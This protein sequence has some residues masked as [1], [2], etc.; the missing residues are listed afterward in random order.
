[1]LISSAMKNCFFI[2]L[3]LVFTACQSKLPKE[4]TLSDPQLVPEGIAYSAKTHSFYISSIAQSKI[5][6]VDRF[7]GKQE[8]F[9]GKGAFGYQPGVGILVDD[10]NNRLYALGGYY[11]LKDSIAALY[12][13]DLTTQKLLKRY[14]MPQAGEHF[15]NDLIKDQAGNLYMTNTKDSS[16]YWL[17]QN[18][19]SLELFY[20]SKEITFPNGI[21][22]SDDNAKL[23]VASFPGGV[24]I[25]DLKE[26]KL[27]NKADS[28]G[29][30]NGIDGLE[31]YKGNLY[32]VQNGV[33]ANTNNFRKLL[34]NN[35]QDRI[36]GFQVIDSNNPELELPLTFCV[37]GN[38]AV[39]IANSNLQ[40]W[41]Q[42]T[43]QF[44][45]PPDSLKKTK[46]LVYELK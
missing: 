37:A 24:R 2:L 1:M 18:G 26:K 27:L 16:I 21:A 5:V 31:F 32:A 19:D 36:T 12:A 43:L 8:D 35:T 17:K 23:Y 41:N 28:A 13:F 42:T 4:Y 44:D 3:I 15:L 46:L 20:K 25:L 33:Q 10:Q 6:K 39:V 38:Q 45:I 22:I 29:I 30:S 11:L 34:L 40:Y 7:T 9:I 14:D